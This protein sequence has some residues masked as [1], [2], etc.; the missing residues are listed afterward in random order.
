MIGDYVTLVPRTF[1]LGSGKEVTLAARDVEE[2]LTKE[3]LFRLWVPDVEA[4]RKYL[5]EEQ[6]FEAA[7]PSVPKGERYSLRKPLSDE[8]ELHVR[9]YGDGFADAEVEVRRE[10]F[11][12]L[13]R[14]LN[15]VYEA[16][17]Y[18]RGAYDRLHVWYAPEREWVVGVRDH[19]EVRLR[20]PDSLTPWAPVVLGIV[21][22]ALAVTSY[23]LSRL[24]RGGG[25]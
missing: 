22:A 19:F 8:W 6:G 23:A 7:V 4:V 21:A 10:Y 24:S 2:R 16:F 1:V 15:V 17:E 3:T 18:Y 14:R 25:G 12:H 13:A 20:R 11:E 5:V 9:L